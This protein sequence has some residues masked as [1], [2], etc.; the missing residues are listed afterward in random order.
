MRPEWLDVIRRPLMILANHEREYEAWINTWRFDRTECRWVQLVND[1]R[2]L[3][4]ANV[5]LVMPRVRDNRQ[6]TIPDFDP[7]TWWEQRGGITIN[8]P[9]HAMMKPYQFTIEDNMAAST[10]V[11]IAKHRHLDSING[12]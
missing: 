1:L 10:L 9:A 3:S 2:G 8:I 6:S 5:L 7:L 11:Q 4:F 12:R